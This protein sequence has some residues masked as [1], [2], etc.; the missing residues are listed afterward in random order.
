MKMTVRK[1]ASGYWTWLGLIS[2]QQDSSK[3]LS[4][5]QKSTI[6][7][8]AGS[9]RR[10][11]PLNNSGHRY[12]QYERALSWNIVTHC[13]LSRPKFN[14]TRWVWFQI[15]S[16]TSLPEYRPIQKKLL[17]IMIQRG[18]QIYITFKIYVLNCLCG[19]LVSSL[20]L[21]HQIFI[22]TD[23]PFN[24]NSLRKIMDAMLIIRRNT[25]YTRGNVISTDG[26]KIIIWDK[27]T[28]R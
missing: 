5:L 10:G 7:Y 23:I 8:F 14:T 17:S 28:F 20:T 15:P 24:I 1:F 27:L 12:Q 25:N 6:L 2:I 19:K 9:D 21:T 16:Y 18:I 22:V 11:L 3:P 13:N 26:E 4:R